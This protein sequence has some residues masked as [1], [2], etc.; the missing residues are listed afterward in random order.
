[1]VECFCGGGGGGENNRIVV[2][3]VVK[4]IELWRGWL[5]RR[6]R[7]NCFVCVRTINPFDFVYGREQFASVGLN[8]VS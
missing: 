7:E 6:R 3:V 1:M 4:T 8:N 5:W 2:V